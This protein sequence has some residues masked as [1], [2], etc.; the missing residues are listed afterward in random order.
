MNEQST[1]F[2]MVFYYFQDPG[3]VLDQLVRV[4]SDFVECYQ[5]D[6]TRISDS[7]DRF[8]AFRESDPG[9]FLGSRIRSH[10]FSR[11]LF[12]L[13]T[14]SS[15][16]TT[17]TQKLLFWGRRIDERFKSKTPNY[18]YF[19]LPTTIDIDLRWHLFKEAFFA[20]DFHLGLGNRVIATDEESMPRSGANA[21]KQ[22]RQSQ[23]F[24]QGF[25]AS[26]RNLSYLQVLEQRTTKF[27]MHPS[28]FVGVGREL[29]HHIDYAG[30]LAASGKSQEH[31]EFWPSNEA[32]FF[33]ANDTRQ[34]VAMSEFLSCHYVDVDRPSMF[35]KKEEW[36]SWLGKVR[37]TTPGTI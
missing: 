31:F 15:K 2:G 11:S 21:A 37:G 5:E 8:K 32:F 23:L 13:L 17:P 34:L 20:I 24:A 26:F 4:L 3:T 1:S 7:G 18:I 25:D 36:E 28:Q 19:E 12:L 27:L 14:N 10:D 9:S 16:V 30:A 29:Q 35:W 6:F 22:L 33:K